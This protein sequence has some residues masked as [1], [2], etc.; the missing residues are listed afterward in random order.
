MITANSTPQED[1][2]DLR[3]L[4]P[5]PSIASLEPHRVPGPQ[6]DAYRQALDEILRKYGTMQAF[7]DAAGQQVPAAAA[8]AVNRSDATIPIAAPAP[9]PPVPALRPSPLETITAAAPT[10][11]P[12]A[13]PVAQPRPIETVSAAPSPYAVDYGRIMDTATSGAPSPARPDFTGMGPVP[14]LQRAP[15][16]ITPPTS[17]V[18]APPPDLVAQAAAAYPPLRG[19]DI[20]SVTTPDQQDERALEFWPP[21]EEGDTAHPRP[22]QLPIDRIGVQ[23]LR[24]GLKPKD[25]AADVVSHYLV[26]ND[27]ALQPLYQQFAATFNEPGPR[28]RLERDYDYARKNEGETRPFDVWAERTRIPAYFRGYVFQQWPDDFNAVAFTPQQKQIL[29]QASSYLTSNATGGQATEQASEKPQAPADLGLQGRPAR[30]A[31]QVRHAID[32]EDF[33]TALERLR[34]GASL[35][36]DQARQRLGEEIQAGQQKL[37]PAAEQPAPDREWKRVFKQQY[38]LDA[39]ELGLKRESDAGDVVDNMV[40]LQRQR[41]AP[42]SVTIA[43]PDGR[44]VEFPG[45]MTPV[46][47]GIAI[48]KAFPEYAQGTADALWKSV[49]GSAVRG[50][51]LTFKGLAGMQTMLAQQADAGV[52]ARTRLMS[53]LEMLA[54]APDADTRDAMFQEL[55]RRAQREIGGADYQAYLRNLAR[56]R[57]GNRDWLDIRSQATA[58]R[59]F[60]DP[61]T[62]TADRPLYR[63]GANIDKGVNR[64]FAVMPEQADR[65]LMQV[66]GA[67][68]YTVP[69]F[70][71]GAVHP[72]VGVAMAAAMGA[73]QSTE[74]AVQAGASEHDI[75]LAAAMGTGPGSIDY[76]PVDF[77]LRFVAKAHP[78]GRVASTFLAELAKRAIAEGVIEG[79]TEGVQQFLQNTI[80]SLTYDPNQDLW[81]DVPAN[82]KVG[83]GAGLLFGLPGGAH[84]AYRQRQQQHLDRESTSP[85]GRVEELRA[86]MEG[87]P[88]PA[89]AEKAAAAQADQAAAEQ[90]KE[91]FDETIDAARVP[92][93]GSR[94]V[95]SFPDGET[96]TLTVKSYD[97]DANGEI[98]VTLVD[99]QGQPAYQG[100]A[101]QVQ[102]RVLRGRGT[103]AEPIEPAT[104]ADVDEAGKQARQPSQAQAEAGNYRHGHVTNLLGMDVAIETPLGAARTGT[105][106]DGKPWSVDMPAH[107]GRIKGTVGADGEEMD[108]YIGPE[109]SPTKP[110]YIVDQIDP[111]TGKFDEHKVIV[112]VNNET[113]AEELYLSGFSDNAAK[114]LGAITEMSL[115]QFHAWLEGGKTAEP[116]T[117]EERTHDREAGG[118]VRGAEPRRPEEAGRPLPEQGPGGEAPAGDRI[119]QGEGPSGEEVASAP[120]IPERTQQREDALDRLVGDEPATSTADATSSTSQAPSSTDADFDPDPFLPA[121]G[122]YVSQTREPLNGKAMA[123]RIE[124]LTPAQADRV[125]Q[126]LASEPNSGLQQ[127]RRTGKLRRV[128]TIKGPVDVL[129][130]VAMHGG[131]RDDEGHDLAKGRGL[132]RLVP[133]VGA[134]IRP[135]GRSVDEVGELLWEAGYFPPGTERPSE[136]QVLDLLDRAAAEPV[137]RPDDAVEV[138]DRQAEKE[139]GNQ[140]AEV[141]AAAADLGEILSNNDVDE[142][143]HIM[144]DSNLD[145]AAAVEGYIESQAIADADALA[146]EAKDDIYEE[147]PFFGS[148]EDGG[149]AGTGRPGQEGAPGDAAAR[150]DVG[151]PAQEA[152]GARPAEGAGRAAEDVVD[153]VEGPRR[154]TVIPGAE[155]RSAAEVRQHERDQAQAKAVDEAK[156]RQQQSKMRR[157]GQ[158]EADTTPLFGHG[159][160]GEI[161]FATG[162]GGAPKDIEESIRR[163]R[164]ALDRV[165]ASHGTETRAMHRPDVGWIEFRWGNRRAGIAH[166]ILRGREALLDRLPEIIARG[167]ATE[168]YDTPRGRARRDIVFGNAKVVLSPETSGAPGT[169]VVTA[170]EMGGENTGGSGESADTRMN[171]TDLR[172][173]GLSS[174]PDEGAEPREGNVGDGTTDDNTEFRVGPQPTDKLRESKAALKAEILQIAQRMNPSVNVRFVDELF[175]E[176]PALLRSGAESAERQEVAGSYVRLHNLAKVSLADKFDPHDTAFHELWHSIERELTPEEQAVL[177]KAFPPAAL[178]SREEAIAIAYADWATKRRRKEQAQGPI[179]KIFAKVD[180]FLKAVAKVFRGA[181]FTSADNIFEAGYRGDIG[182]RQYQFAG[183]NPSV[184]DLPGDMVSDV[185]GALA[186]VG[187]KPAEA[188]KMTLE[189]ARRHLVAAAD[190]A[191]A[192]GRRRPAAPL[193]GKLQAVHDDLF[194][195]SHKPW[196][197][198]WRDDVAT[199]FEAPRQAFIDQFDAI[200]RLERSVTGRIQDAAIS[201]YKLAQRTQNLQGV[202]FAALKKGPLRWNDAEG[203]FEVDRNFGYGFEDILKPLA[204]RGELDAWKMWAV[205]RRMER[206]LSEGRENLAEQVAAAHGYTKAGPKGKTVGDAAAMLADIKQLGAGKPHFQ[207]A[208]D[209]W[210]RFN[211]AMLDMAEATGLLNATQR[212]AWDK[213][214]YIPFYRVLDE[215]AVAT[216]G[217]RGR[218]LANQRGPFQQLRGGEQK[219]NDP[220]ENMVL[221]MT[222]LVD[223]AFKNQAM[224]RVRDLAVASGV[225]EPHAAA[226]P[227]PA[228]IPA[229]AARKALVDAGINVDVLS[230]AERR[231]I[232]STFQ[233]VPP[234]AGDVVSVMDDGSPSYYQV[235]DAAL[236]RA[237]V[238]MTP[239]QHGLIVRLLSLPKKLLTETVTADPAF[240]IR[241]AFRD[242]LSAGVLTGTNKNPFSG[243]AASI[244]LDD[245][246]IDIFAAGGGTVGFYR[247]RA[248]DVRRH[249]ER[250]FERRRVTPKGVWEQWQRV[251]FASENMNRVAIYRAMR[252]NGASVAEAVHE[253]QDLMNFSAHGDA[254]LVR[255][256]ISVVP[257]LN[258]RI[259]GLD[260]LYRGFTSGPPGTTVSVPLPGG[261][262]MTLNKMVLLRGAAVV[263][264]SMGYWAMVHD[265]QRYQDLQEWDKDLYYH[266]W[267]GDRHFKLPKPFEIGALFSTMPERMMNTMVHGET[268]ELTDSIGRMFLNTFAF[269][270]IPQA[271]L[272]LFE[273][274]INE[275]IFFGTP[276]VSESD[277]R[278]AETPELQYSAN[279]SETARLI[280]DALPDFLPSPM[281]SPK[282]IEALV[283]G[284]TGTLG[285]YALA[286]ADAASRVILDEGEKPGRRGAFDRPVVR[287]FVREGPEFT[288]WTERYY[289]LRNKAESIQA[290][291]KRAID[292]GDVERA[293]ELA[294]ENKP[295]LRFR[296]RLN[297]M[298]TQLGK[299]RAMSRQVAMDPKM[300]GE[301]KRRRLDRIQEEHNAVVKQAKEIEAIIQKGRE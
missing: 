211:G 283:Q 96:E 156:V 51:G 95:A 20:A 37:Q 58:T 77:M 128:Q 257:F 214:D 158:L 244:K 250:E 62:A 70:I 2:D 262:T 185:L 235:H 170:F 38:G 119:L 215:A 29:D 87:E 93:K 253:A 5:T 178:M 172:T 126:K 134:L 273:Q 191:Y 186:T 193:P 164:A 248:A 74:Q 120:D 15:Q 300:S 89:E 147:I 152:G 210:Q 245:D 80:V 233:L 10:P 291:I 122:R 50:F 269:N 161:E 42:R 47:M 192:L 261:R 111:E 188:V 224:R 256:M 107:Y 21:G 64:N 86:A 94:V 97:L 81:Q 49:V 238:N 288:K 201:A 169:W 138:A 165:R 116:L 59:D 105:G 43:L 72:A 61:E 255:F 207:D 270:P 171:R 46:E 103:K 41:S 1:L 75:G 143:V 292:Y 280:A 266:F 267:I 251:G 12:A 73:G 162:R 240:M 137:Y 227:V 99:D 208:W 190:P 102:M 182:R 149:A 159:N 66:V 264:A 212:A 9:Q 7:A 205:G 276:I 117:Y 260:R 112:G 14:T 109:P 144:G 176:G 231:Q 19:L 236:L 241:N 13:A 275:K 129:T 56:A 57:A 166:I 226:E 33:G 34:A 281:R 135:G 296:R 177:Q 118:G 242:T 167:D 181:G 123:R 36:P 216:P 150:G 106:K 55:R 198:K 18:P 78:A 268:R 76:A 187:V 174:L 184:A 287:S 44:Q 88:A 247:T 204:A 146:S 243:F 79:T 175:G 26:N 221:N 168:P 45:T 278:L 3:T 153:T 142:I 71:A 217:G 239:A 67:A 279:T 104:P 180:E 100:S 30:I 154:Q 25:I 272:P 263:A 140:R 289:E 293:K 32:Q 133:K 299:L 63:M 131:I 23:L 4:R 11:A 202:M 40:E 284:Y 16:P 223:A 115:P 65:F 92:A 6:G 298:A 121:A 252:A 286:A 84:G 209:K 195:T 218:G 35:L 183:K 228:R 258:A 219:L 179:A 53:A 213:S 125:L 132:A 8:L 85:P 199:Y 290:G 48:R 91:A 282:R 203:H 68:G 294:E 82:I 246:L 297:K 271:L 151:A 157:G 234:R 155:Q 136:A 206:L 114:R 90:A 222:Y 52:D 127:Q 113:E 160:Q 163:G 197:Q 249:V 254:E 145:A 27:P 28:Q 277:Q 301:E 295:L 110:V 108:I 98:R 285:T 141:R 225:M 189:T 39:D 229:T 31:A 24:N 69:L 230:A 124:G 60:F 200:A 220:I 130:F 274:A 265:D 148:G 83:F 54:A 196:W 101:R 173:S 139:L 194:G 237:V 17:P 22:S 232:L 259:Q